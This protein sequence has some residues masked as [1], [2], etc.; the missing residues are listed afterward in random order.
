MDIE[1]IEATAPAARCVSIEE[2]KLHLRVDQSAEDG[3]IAAYLDAAIA[4][5]EHYSG[6]TLNQRQFAL[7][8]QDWSAVIALP[9]APL[10]SVD[11]V[12]YR[13]TNETLQTVDSGLYFV[14]AP[15]SACPWLSFTSAFTSPDLSDKPDPIEVTVTA[16]YDVTDPSEAGP[17][18]L[19]LPAAAKAAIL[20]DV[21]H[22]YANRESVQVKP[23]LTAAVE[24]PRGVKALLSTIRVYR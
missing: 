12:K 4:A 9:L 16:G 17:A 6:R 13:D 2:A 11:S 14:G 1:I 24:L 7:Y 10:V 5:C 18:W 21:G 8:L 15:K 3:S 19:A 20:L 22:L 23:G